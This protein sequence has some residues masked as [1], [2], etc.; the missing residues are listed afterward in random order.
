MTPIRIGLEYFTPWTNDV[1]YQIAIANDLYLQQGLEVR[2]V[3][4]D[5]L[6]GDTLEHLVRGEVDI[7]V[8]PTNRLLKRVEA[9]QALRGIATINHRAMET[10]LTTTSTGIQRPLDLQGRRVAFNPTPRGIALVRHLITSDGGDPDSMIIVDSGSREINAD[11]IVAGFADAFFGAYWAWDALFGTTP[12]AQR[13]ALPVDEIGML[14]YPSYVLAVRADSMSTDRESLTKFLHA[15]EQGFRLA[16]S[17]HA[18][19]VDVAVRCVPYVKPELIAHSLNILPAT[20]FDEHGQ[21]GNH[22]WTKHRA[23]AQWLAQHGV[24]QDASVVE[25]TLID[26][27][28]DAVS[29]SA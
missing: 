9:G 7:A 2:Q 16:A 22:P 24:L 27:L 11:D 26:D 15:S 3:L 10:I 19:A 4:V 23:Y 25:T 21:W 17:D 28:F 13:V 14:A 20:W 8:C 5:P 1:G 12:S 18:L 29:E 6:A